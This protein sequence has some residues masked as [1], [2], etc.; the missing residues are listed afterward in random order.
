MLSGVYTGLLNP[1][2]RIMGL[3]LPSGGHLTHGYYTNKKKISATSI[4]FE[5]LPYKIKEDGYIDYDNLERLTRDF[6]PKL[7]ICDEPVSSLDV[8]VQAQI[9]NLLEELKNKFNLTLLFIS[10]DLSLVKNISDRIAVMYLGKICEL[11]ESDKLYEKPLHPYTFGLIK[12]IPSLSTM[13][14][15]NEE[16]MELDF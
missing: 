14:R 5:S 13:G 16:N 3:D 7:I 1:H 9:I 15:V 8:S 4:F 11:A 6:K 12:A 2:D 10:H